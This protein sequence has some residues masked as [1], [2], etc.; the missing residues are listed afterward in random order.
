MTEDVTRGKVTKV[1]LGK[2]PLIEVPFHR[3]AINLVGPLIPSARGHRY[4]LT[5]V[6]YATRYVE[7]LPLKRIIT[8]KVAEQLVSIFS[9]VGFPLE[10]LSEV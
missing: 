2:M 5:V 8:V 6:D 3:I 4:I 9:R 10:M 7:A 1:P